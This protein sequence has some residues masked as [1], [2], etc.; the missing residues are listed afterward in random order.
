MVAELFTV[1][2]ATAPSTLELAGAN[3]CVAM[4]LTAVADDD[5]SAEAASIIASPITS[6][7][8]VTFVTTTPMGK[9]AATAAVE[10]V[11][12]A[13]N[14]PEATMLP[15]LITTDASAVGNAAMIVNGAAVAV[16]IKLT[17]PPLISPATV[18]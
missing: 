9:L 3:D 12:V 16:A 4:I 2:T 14:A 6:T 13:V 10:A 8:A 17:S 7:A 18:I 11:A 1:E 5:R 15:P